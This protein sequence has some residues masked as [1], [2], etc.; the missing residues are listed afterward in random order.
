MGRQFPGDQLP[1]PIW[2][3]ISRCRRE[4]KGSLSLSFLPIFDC[5]VETHPVRR[6]SFLK[7]TDREKER[8]FSSVIIVRQVIEESPLSLSPGTRNKKQEKYDFRGQIKVSVNWISFARRNSP[9]TTYSG[10][11]ERSREHLFSLYF[12]IFT[13]LPNSDIIIIDFKRFLKFYY[14]ILWKNRPLN[15][16]GSRLKAIAWQKQK[17]H[18]VSK[19]SIFSRTARPGMTINLASVL[20]ETR[21]RLLVR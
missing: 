6:V 21:N 14:H 18:I 9:S 7:E 1:P 20:N 2:F 12:D 13:F 4:E 15:A 3:I 5:P 11:Q 10:L 16:D 8:D 19:I 17:C